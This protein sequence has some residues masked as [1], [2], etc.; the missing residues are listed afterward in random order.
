[1]K[2]T[3]PVRHRLISPDPA[4]LGQLHCVMHRLD[5]DL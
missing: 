2:L 5:A 1:M 3:V 4:A